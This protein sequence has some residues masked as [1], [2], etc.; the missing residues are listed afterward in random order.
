[1]FKYKIPG[2]L[3]ERKIFFKEKAALALRAPPFYDIFNE[4]F[5]SVNFLILS[6]NH[7][8]IRIRR[9]IGSEIMRTAC[10]IVIR[11]SLRRSLL[12]C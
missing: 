10:G 5:G 9:A 7:F 12:I 4:T 2:F 8:F 3:A 11:L 1:M 6:V